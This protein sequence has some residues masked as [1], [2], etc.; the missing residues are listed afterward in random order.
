L[1]ENNSPPEASVGRRARS[2][3]DFGSASQ[4]QKAFLTKTRPKSRRPWDALA[5]AND[6]G[7]KDGKELPGTLDNGD[8][9]LDESRREYRYRLPLVYAILDMYFNAVYSLYAD[10]LHL[11]ENHLDSLIRDADDVLALLSSLS[12]CFKAVEAQTSSFM[13]QCD[14][15]LNDQTRLEGL[16][17]EVG[18]NLHYYAYLDNVSRRLNAPGAGRLVDYD[19]FGDVL[20]N[21]E[22]CIAFMSKHVS[23][24]E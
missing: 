2:F 18:T 14:G 9:L 5:L 17:N 7:I 4:D 15:L 1:Q 20:D 6:E 23:A 24:P 16:A 22:S 12:T 19:E 11:T 3:A 13:D 21:L 8:H 10:Q